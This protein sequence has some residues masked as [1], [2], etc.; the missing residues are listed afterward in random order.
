MAYQLSLNSLSG[1]H[2]PTLQLLITT[3]LVIREN[4][5]NIVI[6][7]K[8]VQSKIH[9]TIPMTFKHPKLK[10]QKRPKHYIPKRRDNSTKREVH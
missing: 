4:S 7:M 6:I 5:S 2:G 3:N 8:R 9:S 10:Y 1:L